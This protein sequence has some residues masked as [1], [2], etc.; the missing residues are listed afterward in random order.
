MDSANE[1]I[2]LDQVEKR[3]GI[4]IKNRQLWLEALTHKSWLYFHPQTHLSHNERLEFL[5]DAVLELVISWYLWKHYTAKE[6]GELT[7]IRAELVKRERLSQIAEKLDLGRFLLIGKNIG[8]R[9]LKTVL[10]NA[11]EAV[12]GAIFID[13][14]LKTAQL[15]IEKHFLSDLSQ[16]VQGRLYKDPKSQLQEIFQERFG[17]KP[18]YRIMSE[19][20]QAHEKKFKTGIFYQ[21]RLLAVGEGMSKQESEIKAATV[22]L[23]K[24]M[25]EKLI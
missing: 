22:V 20:G 3:L 4:K 18:T 5:G 12:I 6:E 2:Q 13:Y 7:L 1:L 25:W 17:E 11:L 19:T 23:K 24:K 14:D 21:D 10:G 8:G 16:I 9:G 15:F